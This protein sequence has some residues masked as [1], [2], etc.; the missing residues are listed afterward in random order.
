MARRRPRRR[1]ESKLSPGRRVMAVFAGVG[2]VVGALAGVLALFGDVRDL[3][4]DD[5]PEAI[6]ARIEAVERTRDRMPLGEYLRLVRLP[7]SSFSAEQ[8]AQPGYE[9]VV[10][11]TITGRVG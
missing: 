1:E 3:F 6:D 5:T 8:L 4:K 2:V 9:F 10:T 11:V 7:R